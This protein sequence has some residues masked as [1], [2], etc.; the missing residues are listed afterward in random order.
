MFQDVSF[1]YLDEF[2][3]NYHF[4]LAADIVK[5]LNA[6]DNLQSVVTTH[7]VSLMSNK[8]T[9]PDCVYII[10]NNKINNL[11]NCTEKELREA[12]NIEKLYREGSFTE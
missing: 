3:S 5:F 1:V 2:D 12:H 8:I 9:R 6:Q 4:E 11:S 7:N 10:S